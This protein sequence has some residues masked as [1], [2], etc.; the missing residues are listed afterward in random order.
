MRRR[1]VVAGAVLAAGLG[2]AGGHVAAATRDASAAVA[3]E[4]SGDAARDATA[5]TG[6]NRR[7]AVRDAHA[8]LGGVVPPAGALPGASGA[9]TGAHAPLLTSVTASAVAYRSWTV[10]ESPRTVLAFA[11]A[12]LPPGSKVVSTGSGGPTFSE[13]VTRAWP[14]VS[15]VLG[16]RWLELQVIALPGGTRLYAE[17]QSQWEVVRPRNDRIP[18]TVR[19]IDISETRPG[20]TPF[21]VRRVHSPGDLRAMVRLFNSLGVVQ[22]GTINCPA[23]TVS[24]IVTLR[25]RASPTS[26][27]VAQASV[28]STA[29]YHWPA[30]LPG[31]ACYPIKLAIEGQRA[32]PQLVGNVITPIDRLL[33][34]HL[35]RS[36]HASGPG[37]RPNSHR[38]FG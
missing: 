11:E 6:A 21:L 31:A 19:Q 8:L 27:P 4:V 9:M 36:P 18:G 33:H 23:E 26:T 32:E 37:P 7:A 29:V 10:Q 22:P 38:I 17:S 28:S 24:P 14:P 15:G 1:R 20:K 16:V 25:F 12:H 35:A 30:S 3:R 13:S 5:G 2:L 34:L